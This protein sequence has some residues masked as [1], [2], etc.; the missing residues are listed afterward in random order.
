MAKREQIQRKKKI[1][2]NGES[3]QWQYIFKMRIDTGFHF[4]FSVYKENQ[5][6]IFTYSLSVYIYSKEW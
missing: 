5:H 4:P 2:K 6:L 1:L 3:E